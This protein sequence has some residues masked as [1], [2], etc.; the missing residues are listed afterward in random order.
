[1]ADLKA[2]KRARKAVA[3]FFFFLGFGGANWLARLPAIRH[4][5]G[6]DDRELGF[7]LL[8]SAVGAAVAFRTAHLY[9]RRW[10]N[11][12]LVVGATVGASA[13]LFVPAI[14]PNGPVAALG[15]FLTGYCNGLV[16][17]TVNATAVDVE[18]R[19]KKPIL[20]SMHGFCTL[21]TL[22]GAS[23]GTFATGVQ[24][25]PVAHLMLVGVGVIG[26]SLYAG[27]AL[28]P[29]EGHVPG[30]PIR[31]RY[32]APLILLGCVAF[33]SSVGEG[34]MAQWAAIYLHDELHAS[35]FVANV[36]FNIYTAAMVA[37]RFAGDWLTGKW[38]AHTVFTRCGILV[39]ASLGLGLASDKAY[40]MIASLVGVGLGLSL[41]IPTVFRCAVR[42]PNMPSAVAL[43]S[44]ATL[45]YGGFLFGPPSIGLVAQA[46]SLRWALG[47]VV[48]LGGLMGL[49]GARVSGKMD[50]V[51]STTPAPAQR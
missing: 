19:L 32:T 27:R 18:K 46:S 9:L 51:E 38:R 11:H 42:L 7:V 44:V 5:L 25:P 34:A 43:S 31:T 45:S 41:V 29:E 35:L 13:F 20:S 47:L 1:M 36:G 50:R 4:T 21:G 2:L 24:L 22:A 37:G 10:H 49:I 40:L 23:L 6:L 17:V 39:A 33:C 8:A 12:Q 14:A 3:A 28:L 16:D 26:C 30:P 15:L 48:V